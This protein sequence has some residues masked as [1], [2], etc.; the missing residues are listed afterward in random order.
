MRKGCIKRKEILNIQHKGREL[1]IAIISEE[2]MN[3]D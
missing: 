2:K 1:K 3:S